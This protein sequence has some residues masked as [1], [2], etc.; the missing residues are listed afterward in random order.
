MKEHPAVIVCGYGLVLSAVFVVGCATGSTTLQD[1]G[2]ARI[3]AERTPAERDSLD[4]VPTSESEIVQ[5]GSEFL[6]SSIEGDNKLETVVP[7]PFPAHSLIELEQL[8]VD[9]NPRLVKL[10]REYHAATSRARYVDELPDPKIGANVFGGAAIETAAGSQRAILS[11]S[12]MIP[13][14]GKLSAEEQRASFEA[15]AVRADYLAERLRVIAA[16]RTGWYRLYVIDK[17]IETTKA[18]Q[19][20]L[21]SLTDVANAQIATGT[22]TQGDVLLGT[23]ELSKLEERLLTYRKLRVAVQAEVNRLLARDTEIPVIT[24]KELHVDLPA[25]SLNT[26]F[27]NS[28]TS[29]PEIQAAQLRTQATQWG[30]EVARLSRRPELTISGNYFFVDNNRPPSSVVNVGEDPWS[31]GAQVSVPLWREKYDALE[32]EA[33]WKHLASN[34]SETEVIDRYDALITELLAE[35]RRAEETAVLYKN[36]I[37]PQARQTLRAD[38]ESYSRGA[39]EFDRVIRDYRNLLTLELGYHQAI[40]ELAISMAQISRAVGQDTPMTKLPSL[41]VL[42]DEN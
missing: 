1:A 8:A 36:T 4:N 32:D 19:E 26:L 28:L 31:L 17:Q 29:Q 42:P 20:L 2:S 33:T 30:I 18:N 3:E 15:F 14:L 11:A 12:Q 5:T 13:W 21:K 35:A 7:Q 39:V 38:Q 24:S 10:Y 6:D 9:M 16:V 34:N 41:P 40:G 23:L 22:A 27:Q 25:L 37:L